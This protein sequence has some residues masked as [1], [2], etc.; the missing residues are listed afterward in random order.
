V[1]V[2]VPPP[3]TAPP[4]NI[5]DGEVVV[6]LAIVGAK[7]VDILRRGGDARE[8]FTGVIERVLPG[9]RVEQRQSLNKALFIAGL[10]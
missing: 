8:R 3:V 6:R 9:E 2:M 7:V 5:G 10:Q 4:K 1:P